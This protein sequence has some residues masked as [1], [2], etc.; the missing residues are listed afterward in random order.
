MECAFEGS[1]PPG[2][3]G[4]V[5]LWRWIFAETLGGNGTVGSGGWSARGRSTVGH[6][7][8]VFGT[9]G[10]PGPGI[11]EVP[12]SHP[13]EELQPVGHGKR[14]SRSSPRLPATVMGCACPLAVTLGIVCRPCNGHRPHSSPREGARVPPTQPSTSDSL[15]VPPSAIFPSAVL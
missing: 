6:V 15:S 8:L 10:S 5:P 4:K 7:V 9:S 11:C 3:P 14:P 2:W 1:G 12:V 13:G